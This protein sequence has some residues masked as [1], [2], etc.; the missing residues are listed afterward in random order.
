MAITV[1]FTD[2]PEAALD[3]AGGF[4]AS[5]PIVHNLVLSLLERRAVHPMP[6]RYWVASCDGR[7]VGLVFQSPLDFRATITPMP[8]D[9]VDAVVAAIVDAGV[10]LPGV[11]GEARTAARFAGQW[12]EVHNAAAAPSTGLRIY[13]LG[14]LVP[15]APLGGHLRRAEAQDL[16]IVREYLDGFHTSTGERSDPGMIDRRV[17]AGSLWFWDDNGPRSIAG[18]GE[19]AAGVVR[20]GPVYTPPAYRNRGYAGACVAGLSARLVDAGLR[21]MLYT[22]LGN[23]VSNSVYRRLGYRAAAECLQYSFEYR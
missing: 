7:P 11:S 15:P 18:H 2:R 6:G 4:L 23:P 8:D 19:P 14:Q 9:A 21:C 13:A 1:D 5:S 10:R 16:D 20:I 17:A 12:T 22:D 3:F